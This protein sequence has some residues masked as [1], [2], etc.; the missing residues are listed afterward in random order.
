M[1]RIF[2]QRIRAVI[3]TG[4]GVLAVSVG[5]DFG[6][7]GV[8]TAQTISP[9]T[10]PVQMGH[11]FDIVPSDRAAMGNVTIAIDDALLDPFVNPAK[12]M[13]LKAGVLSVAPYFYSQSESR[14]G[15]R[16]LPLSGIATTGKWAFGGLFAVQQLDR[17]QLTWNAPLSERTASNQYV[18][19]LIARSLGNG[20][21]IG[22]SA[23]VAT[24]EAEQGIDQLYSGSDRILQNGSASDARVGLTRQWGEGRNFEAMV[25]RSRFDMTHDV[26]FPGFR[27]FLPPDSFAV[28]AVERTEHNR[29]NTT[30][31]GA[32]SE[33]SRPVGSEGWKLGVLGTVNR[34]SH[35][36]I[37]DYRVNEV[38]TVPRD[39]GHT[40]AYNAGM[41]M[42]RVF[43]NATFAFDVILEPMFSTTWAEAGRDTVT[44][45]GARILKGGHTVDNTFRFSNSLMRFGFERM[46]P[47]GDSGTHFGVQFGMGVYAVRYRLNQTDQ[48]RDT[49][50]VQNEHW[51]E[52]TPSVGFKVRSAG[53]EIRYALSMTCGA[54]GTCM[55][56][57]FACGQDV[58]TVASPSDGGVIAAPT[59]VLRFNGGRVTTQRITVSLRIR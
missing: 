15:G 1:L 22:A 55:P 16:T 33:Y 30:M 41:G 34:L 57:A 9:R 8:L 36:K 46:A 24:L 20:F 54:G 56:C 59:D 53:Y 50:R 2:M 13:R 40:W 35:P 48:I 25:L 23:Y 45:A 39:P 27:R 11:Q 26:H 44:T 51:M 3:S 6:M 42:S 5:V 32:H 10:V 21:A 4:V 7:V 17:A 28:I 49:S 12:A 43:S 29:D 52:W 31:W 58:T 37:P 18:S 38:I 47:P 19:G 14:G